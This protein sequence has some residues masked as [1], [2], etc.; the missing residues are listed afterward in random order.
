MSGRRRH[1][2]ARA[3]RV[4]PC[5][6]VPHPRAD[7]HTAGAVAVIAWFMAGALSKALIA[8]AIALFVTLP[9][10]GMGRGGFGGYHGGFGGGRGG[11]LFPPMAK[12]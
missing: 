7:A 10:G 4:V 11:A 8:G 3:A 1:S 6:R 9:G 12:A 2:H 5:A